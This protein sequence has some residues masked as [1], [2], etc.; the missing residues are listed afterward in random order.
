MFCSLGRRY[1]IGKFFCIYVEVLTQ[2]A[3]VRSS[4]IRGNIC[5]V[6]GL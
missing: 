3:G 6:M 2:N 4:L 5:L 1:H